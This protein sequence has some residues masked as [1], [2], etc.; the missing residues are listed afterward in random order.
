[1][2]EEKSQEELD[3][4][5][6]EAKRKLD[7][8]LKEYLASVEEDDF[9]SELVFGPEV[10]TEPKS[11]HEDDSDY[12]TPPSY[13]ADKKSFTVSKTL[14]F[15][16]GLI[17]VFLVIF[18]VRSWSTAKKDGPSIS[19]YENGQKKYESHYKNGKRDGLLTRWHK[20]GQKSEE[21]H[22]K[23]GELEGLWTMWYENGQKMEE[24]HYKNDKRDGP[25]TVWYEN[26]QKVVEAHFK[27]DNPDGVV[28]RWRKNGEKQSR[29]RYEGG[30]LIAAESW[31]PD[32]SPC[33]FTKIVG[34]WGLLV[35]WYENGQKK[36]ESHY[37]NGKR[38]GPWAEWYPD[39]SPKHLGYYKDGKEH[40]PETEWDEDGEI[41]E[42]EYFIEGE[43]V[44]PYYEVYDY[45]PGYGDY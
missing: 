43:F 25:F 13:L 32:G 28:M 8:S 20:N 5:A 38:H 26:G 1:M 29:T 39:G 44:R 7:Q 35:R 21:H 9:E 30:L 14:L 33:P 19:Y 27:D 10:E 11:P 6:D 24:I 17:L 36:Y 4:A 37:K 3:K 41:A 42:T 12:E 22:Y 31:L 23:N 18:Y 15:W 2:T 34:E 16:V 40:G 45:D